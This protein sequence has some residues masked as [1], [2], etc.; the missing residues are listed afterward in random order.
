MEPFYVF[1]HLKTLVFLE[2]KILSPWI[3]YFITRILDFTSKNIKILPSGACEFTSQEPMV[4]PL[5]TQN[6]TTMSQRFYLPRPNDFSTS[7]R[8]KWLVK[9]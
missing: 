8:S 6:F 1:Y 7:K 2:H 3:K 5:W 9:T 4:L